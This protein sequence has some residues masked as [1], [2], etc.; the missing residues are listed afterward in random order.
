MVAQLSVTLD[1]YHACSFFGL[2]PTHRKLILFEV[3]W[4]LINTKCQP[5]AWS[6]GPYTACAFTTDSTVNIREVW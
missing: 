4:S 1:Q 2:S 3:V 5:T 6:V